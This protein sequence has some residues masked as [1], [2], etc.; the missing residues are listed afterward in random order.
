MQARSSGLVGSVRNRVNPDAFEAE[1]AE[2][3][4][5]SFRQM[6]DLTLQVLEASVHATR[7]AEL[8]VAEQSLRRILSSREQDVLRLVAEGLTS[9]AIGKQLFLSPKTVDHH[10]ASVFNKLGVDTRAQA[11]A[12]ATRQDLV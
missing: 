8:E 12:V 6:A 10:L 5:Q 1:L 9:K 2:G 3:R 11:V 4:A 7:S